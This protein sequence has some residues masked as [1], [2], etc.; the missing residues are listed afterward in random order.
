M[1]RYLLI[2]INVYPS[3]LNLLYWLLFFI[4]FGIWWKEYKLDIPKLISYDIES[5]GKELEQIFSRYLNTYSEFLLN[6]AWYLF[7]YYKFIN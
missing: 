5:A 6:I 2:K 3:R 7:L 1:I 4:C